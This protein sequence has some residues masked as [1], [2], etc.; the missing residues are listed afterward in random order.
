MRVH[1]LAVAL[2]FAL[3]FKYISAISG[4]K[5]SSGKGSGMRDTIES[6]TF[7]KVRAGVQL[8][9]KISTEIS[10]ESLILGWYILVVKMIYGGWNGYNVGKVMLKKKAPPA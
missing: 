5:G 9:L 10:P 6:N 2:N 3:S 8:S 4:T 7:G 1:S